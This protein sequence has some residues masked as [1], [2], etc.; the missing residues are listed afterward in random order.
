LTTTK[1]CF[2]DNCHRASLS[3]WSVIEH[4]TDIQRTIHST[5]SI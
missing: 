5:S 3:D 2:K 1:N 4:S